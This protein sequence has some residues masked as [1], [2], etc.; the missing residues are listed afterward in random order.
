MSENPDAKL[1]EQFKAR[2][3]RMVAN[4]N[5]V[6]LLW[7]AC[8]L[9]LFNLW[10]RWMDASVAQ[11]NL[12]LRLAAAGLLVGAYCLLRQRSWALRFAVWTYAAAFLVG[13][14]SVAWAVLR[15]PGAFELGMP[16]LL[17]FP[18]ALAYFPLGTWRFLLI[19]LVGASGMALMCWQQPLD[20]NAVLNFFMLYALSVSIGALALRVLRGQHLLLFKLEREHAL[21]ARTD[22]LTGLANRRSLEEHAAERLQAARAERRPVSVLMLDLD[23]FKRVNDE[24]GHDV[25]DL[26]FVHTARRL[27]QIIRGSDLLGRW[28][29]EEFLAIIDGASLEI[30]SQL[31]ARCIAELVANPLTLPSGA[32]LALGISIGVAE[33]HGDESL[34]AL[35]KRADA[36]LYQA[37][38]AGRGTYRASLP[39]TTTA[40]EGAVA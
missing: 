33:R 18:L 8:C 12:W 26:A 4:A 29:G 11:S 2:R 25:G 3:L 22:V 15:I 9:V 1:L 16:G 17:L 39:A 5:P 31:A 7:L 34:D 10:D 35:V 23:H 32:S 27:S 30:A 14:W 21:S 19:N 28:G 36:A 6:P 24:H 40:P 13:E 20:L 38:E 37:K